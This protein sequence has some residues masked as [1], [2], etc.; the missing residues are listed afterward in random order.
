MAMKPL[1]I[2]Q[3]K[4]INERHAPLINTTYLLAI[5]IEGITA[6]IG[7]KSINKVASKLRGEIYGSS[8]NHSEAFGEWADKMEELFMDCESP[9]YRRQV[10]YILCDKF[11]RMAKQMEDSYRQ[12]DPHFDFYQM[13]EAKILK[14]YACGK[15]IDPMIYTR[16]NKTIEQIKRS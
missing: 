12:I 9:F 7:L 5:V 8:K 4:R 14:A 1:T 16:I 11:Y 3:Q 2:A 15:E 10:L 13:K 6:D